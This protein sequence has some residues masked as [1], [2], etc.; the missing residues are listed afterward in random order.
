MVTLTKIFD[1]ISPTSVQTIDTLVRRF[2]DSNLLALAFT[3][4]ESA[5][6]KQCLLD[7]FQSRGQAAK[8]GVGAPVEPAPTGLSRLPTFQ[9]WTVGER[10]FFVPLASAPQALVAKAGGTEN[11]TGPGF[12]KACSMRA[13][14]CAVALGNRRSQT[15][16]LLWE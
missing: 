12:A 15:I 9:S 11:E 1:L 7:F 3:G 16:A 2:Y 13:T 8:R 10:R 4:G 6:L 5:G 14:V